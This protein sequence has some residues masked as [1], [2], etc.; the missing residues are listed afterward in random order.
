MRILEQIGIS[1]D[2]QE[3]LQLLR[4]KNSSSQKGKNHKEPS[5]QL[6][7]DIESL[8]KEALE[9]IDQYGELIPNIQWGEE[10]ELQTD[11]FKEARWPW[12]K[13]DRFYLRGINRKGMPKEVQPPVDGWRDGGAPV[14]WSPESN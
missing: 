5:P 6:L 11:W 3:I 4:S 1:L 2:S 12:L 9:L 10:L 14:D 8:K 7:D 13:D